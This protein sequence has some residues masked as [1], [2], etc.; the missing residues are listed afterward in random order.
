M[1]YPEHM[2][3]DIRE[4]SDIVE[5]ISAYLELKPSGSSYV[6]LCPFHNEGSPSFN[7]DPGK[8]LYYC[9]GCGVGGNAYSF[10]MSIEGLSFPESV[11]Y[12]ARRINYILPQKDTQLYDEKEALYKINSVAARFFYE[13]LK[14]SGKAVDYLK[15]RGITPQIAKKFGMGYSLPEWD[16]LYNYLQSKGYAPNLIEKTGLVAPGKTGK[17]HYDR[18]RGRLMFPIFE[19]RGK[20]IGFGG[21]SLGEEM[22][23]YINSPETILYNKSESLY[24]L[25][26]I[27]R[28][29]GKD[30]ILVEGY[31]DAIAL[32]QAG[33]YGIA[34]SLGTAFTPAHCRLISRY[35]R[36]VILVFDSDNAG[37]SA[38]MRAINALKTTGLS[39]KILSLKNAK[40]PDEYLKKFSKEDFLQEIKHAKNYIDF[41]IDNLLQNHDI[42]NTQSKIEFTKQAATV[43]AHIKDPVEQEAYISH[44]SNI[45]GISSASIRAQLVTVTL[46]NPIKK[47]TTVKLSNRALNEAVSSLINAIASS[48]A[49]YTAVRPH[50]Q[51][52]EMGSAIYTKILQIL[53]NLYDKD[54]EINPARLLNY[55]SDPK[56]QSIVTDILSVEPNMD[57]KY[58]SRAINDQVK[59]I[60]KVYIETQLKTSE[61]LEHTQELINYRNNVE[62][63]N[64]SLTDG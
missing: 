29:P 60:K 27:K 62:N 46:P 25:N 21:R 26:F 20:I 1:L 15:Q 45:A 41:Q 32:Y 36:G 19:P 4:Q 48:Y 50:L 35:G 63:L 51:P 56:E 42:K 12:L 33:F 49:V 16:K 3:E 43:I 59:L 54:N 38:A 40:D 44:I 34:A 58:L 7:V 55:F 22:P 13:N 23:K 47:P 11:E 18:F 6:G 28:D 64:I 8:Q 5:L 17:Q 53:Y 57:K 10:V 39:I 37:Y 31:M 2:I 24:A 14:S 9:F 61:S 30:I 52:E